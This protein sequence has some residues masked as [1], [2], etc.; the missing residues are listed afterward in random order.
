[1]LYTFCVNFDL[2]FD[3][4]SE[5]SR[6]DKKSRSLIDYVCVSPCFQVLNFNSKKCKILHLGR[7]NP[8]YDYYMHD[9]NKLETTICEKDL[10]IDIDPLLSF[11]DHSD[12]SRLA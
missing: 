8:N 5:Y 2:N 1:M 12:L 3:P 6:S 4:G 11:D 9:G 10:G 7:N